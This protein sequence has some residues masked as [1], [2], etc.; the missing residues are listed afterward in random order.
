MSLFVKNNIHVN[1]YIFHRLVFRVGICPFCSR[2]EKGM[3]QLHITSILIRLNERFTCRC[4]PVPVREVFL[5][6]SRVLKREDKTSY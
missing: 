1:I 5:N 4:T 3:Y 2:K 6:L